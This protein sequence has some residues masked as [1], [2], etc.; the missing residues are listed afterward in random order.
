MIKFVLDIRKKKILFLL[1]TPTKFYLNKKENIIMSMSNSH[2][3]SLQKKKKIKTQFL[4]NKLKR[5]E[6]TNSI[7]HQRI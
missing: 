1:K 5:K 2:T 4:I 3:R 6:K 7:F